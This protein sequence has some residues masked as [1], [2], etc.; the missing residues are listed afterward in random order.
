MRT[1]VLELFQVNASLEP[2]QM[3]LLKGFSGKKTA[4]RQKPS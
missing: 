1:L 3:N 4:K 2:M